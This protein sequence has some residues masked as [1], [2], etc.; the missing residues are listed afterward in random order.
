MIVEVRA[1][2]ES[3]T[4]NLTLVRFL[5]GM[6]ASM[7]VQ[8]AR[9]TETFAAHQTYVRLFTCVIETRVSIIIISIIIT[10]QS[11]SFLLK[12]KR[13]VRAESKQKHRS[14]IEPDTA[15]KPDKRAWC[16]I[17]VLETGL[18]A[19]AIDSLQMTQIASVDRW[20][21]NEADVDLFHIAIETIWDIQCVGIEISLNTNDDRCIEWNVLSK[22]FL[23]INFRIFFGWNVKK[24]SIKKS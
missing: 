17:W 20:M 8:W 6:Y 22:T 9:C 21:H 14:A 23:S 2:G 24:K 4:A 5:A 11:I 18:F 7:C 13:N 15:F 10:H 16:M 1:R 12:L 3:F 19:C